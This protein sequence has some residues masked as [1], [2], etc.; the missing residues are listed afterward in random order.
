MNYL[1]YH[2]VDFVNGPGVRVSL[3]VAGCT[4]RCEGCHSANSWRFDAGLKF[5]EAEAQRLLT[6][7]ADPKIDKAGLSLLGGEPLHPKNIKAVLKLV[8][9]VK[10]Q[11][12]EKSI[13]CWT[14][15]EFGQLNEEQS[16]VLAYIDVLVDGPYQRQ[17]HSAALPW[18]GSS[19][20]RIIKL[21]GD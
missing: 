4:H 12:P 14:G 17:H 9:T 20:Q 1:S 11:F 8:K 3:F 6:D 15:Y 18:R 16:K 13:W 7:L 21:T 10:Q 19:N 5:G 2:N